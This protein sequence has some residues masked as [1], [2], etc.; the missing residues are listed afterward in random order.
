MQE[1]SAELSVGDKVKVVQ[2]EMQG[3]TGF[4]Q[5]FEGEQIVFKPTNIEDFDDNIGVNKMF[6]DKFFE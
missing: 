6:V 2:G 5:S 4:I 3:A 1:L